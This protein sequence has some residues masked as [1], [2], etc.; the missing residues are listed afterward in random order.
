MLDLMKVRLSDGAYD[1][2]VYDKKV[3]LAVFD[4]VGKQGG[5]SFTST[6]ARM[7]VFGTSRQIPNPRIY[8]RY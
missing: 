5:I 7:S 4:I 1:R 8:G 3:R 2:T 6:K